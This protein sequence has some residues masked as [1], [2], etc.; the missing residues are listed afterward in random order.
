M[1]LTHVKTANIVSVKC[2]LSADGKLNCIQ[3]WEKKQVIIISVKVY[4][5]PLTEPLRPKTWS[6][7]Q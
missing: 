3:M 5:Y 6:R 2:W 7:H 4:V 1:R